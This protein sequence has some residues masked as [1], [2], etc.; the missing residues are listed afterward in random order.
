M[1]R[2]TKYDWRGVVLPAAAEFVKSFSTGVTLRQCFYYLV[3]RCAFRA[4]PINRFAPIRS[5][6]SEFSITC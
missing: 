4:K 2:R 1:G 3:S 5:V 6:V